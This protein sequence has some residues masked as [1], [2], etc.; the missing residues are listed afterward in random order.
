M[1][2]L[3]QKISR[4]EPCI[5]LAMLLTFLPACNKQDVK[6]KK[7]VIAVLVDPSGDY[8]YPNPDL[9]FYKNLITTYAGY[10]VVLL[11]YSVHEEFPSAI[12]LQLEATKAAPYMYA[13]DAGT[14]R[15][16]NAE[17][18]ARNTASITTFLQDVD[19]HVI[20]YTF[21][22]SLDGSFIS[23]NIKAI[24]YALSAPEF[25]TYD[26]KVV[27]L[28]TNLQDSPRGSSEKNPVPTDLLQQL[29]KAAR[30]FVVGNPGYDMKV[31]PLDHYKRFAGSLSNI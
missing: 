16:K 3:L 2:K 21:P 19:E 13:P 31:T 18:D 10:E 4:V 17:V 24:Q 28:N 7:V 26:Q 6:T 20:S 15:K 11:V 9:N 27:L 23:E 1:K 5:A 25:D 22:D 30:V 8:H 12:T 29:S 14:V